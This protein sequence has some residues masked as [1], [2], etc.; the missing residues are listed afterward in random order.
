MKILSLIESKGF[1]V[2]HVSLDEV[3]DLL[4]L[5]G[6]RLLGQLARQFLALIRPD[7]VHELVAVSKKLKRDR[8][9]RVGMIIITRSRLEGL[10]CLLVERP[11]ER[12]EP[13]VPLVG[14]LLRQ[15]SADADHVAEPGNRP[16]RRHLAR[17]V[18]CEN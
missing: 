8:E 3:L 14:L 10:T 18:L 9:V 5:L 12:V 16:L 1:L 11:A 17:A 15:L 13:G 4:D 2:T 6:I 7:R